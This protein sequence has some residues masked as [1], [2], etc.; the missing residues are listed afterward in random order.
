MSGIDKFDI[1]KA[2]SRHEKTEKVPYALWKHFVEDDKTAEGLARAQLDFQQKFDSIFMKI[3]PHGSYCVVDFGGILGDYQPV[4]GSRIC[5]RAP[6]LS[7]DDWETLEPVD[8]NEGEFGAQIKVVELITRK[9]ENSVPTV[10]T[11]FSPFMVASKLDPSLLENLNQD[12]R[13]ILEQLQMLTKTMT[14]FATASLDAGTNGIFLATQHFNKSLSSS[15]LQEFEFQP[16]EHILLSTQRKADFN[17]LHLHGDRPY[18]RKASELPVVH[19]INWHDQR[20]SP[21]LGEGQQDFSGALIGGLD[22][23]GILRTGN[24]EEI[25]NA[26]HQVYRQ[27]DGRGLIFGPGCV[28][29]QDLT[30]NQLQNVIKTV[31]SLRPV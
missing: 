23:M 20:T 8:P 5:D 15:N 24:A 4:S 19:A 9:T 14:Q 26:I 28:L 2:I 29:P 18:F 16:L 11:V 10:M 6:I 3:S 22:E 30:D 21:S 1:L 25:K 31:T 17:I 13:L 27:F 12:R 7:L